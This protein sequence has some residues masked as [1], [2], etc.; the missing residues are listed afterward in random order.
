[1]TLQLPP[2]LVYEA[3]FFARFFSLRALFFRWAFRMGTLGC[4]AFYSSPLLPPRGANSSSGSKDATPKL[5]SA[6]K[7]PSSSHQQHEML[8]SPSMQQQAPQVPARKG[9]VLSHARQ[10][11]GD[12]PL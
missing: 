6:L 2:S 11:S 8:Q 7:P 4:C 1:M 12:K 5:L 10:L 9:F 3:F